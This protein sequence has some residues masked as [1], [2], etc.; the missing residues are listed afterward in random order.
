MECQRRTC[1]PFGVSTHFPKERV[2]TKGPSKIYVR[3]SDSG[4]Q[5]ELHFCPNCGS[6]VFWYSEVA[7]D[8]I[9]I[10]IGAFADPSMP[11]PTFAVWETTRHPWVTLALAGRRHASKSNAIFALSMPSPVRRSM[12]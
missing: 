10:A 7:S 6:T 11:W 1:S 4:R 2:R 12:S 9:G 8:L 3:G 5:I